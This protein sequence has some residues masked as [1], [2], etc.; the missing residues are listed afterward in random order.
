M[1]LSIL[2]NEQLLQL[3]QKAEALAISRGLSVARGAKDAAIDAQEA[4]QI[5]AKAFAKAAELA[6]EQERCRMEE[7]ARSEAE[8]TFR[9]KQNQSEAEKV[10]S[11]WEK[12][13][14]ISIALDEWGLKEDWQ[15]NIWSR[16]ADRRI[17]IDGGSDRQ[18]AWKICLYITGNAY[19]A[20]GS[21]DVEGKKYVSN[22]NPLLDGQEKYSE[23]KCFLAAVAQKWHS[24]KVSRGDLQSYSGI[25][26]EKHLA[27]YR[28]ALGIKEQSHV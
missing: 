1:D 6:K 28:Q 22:E 17:Y 23:L 11:L 2:T 13:K 15:I 4:A 24:L 25:A 9:A 18:W 14:A 27:A 8:A 5:R 3:I 19:N 21:L 7:Q 16:G 26:N 12:K 20:P 10:K